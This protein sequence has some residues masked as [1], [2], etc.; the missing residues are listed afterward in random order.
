MVVIIMLGDS[1]VINFKIDKKHKEL[2]FNFQTLKNLYK[3]T[4]QNPFNYLQDFMNSENK[5]D[6]L[7][8]I[9][10]CM[11][12]GDITLEDINDVINN[13][14]VKNY[15]LLN[16]INMIYVELTSEF[17]D[18]EENNNDKDNKND[19]DKQEEKIEE[20]KLQEFENFWNYCYFT[21]T[22]K[23]NKDEEEFYLMSPRE[24]KTLDKYNSNFY[25]NI[26]IDT[27]ITII[28]AKNGNGENKKEEV[29]NVARLSD[30]FH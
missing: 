11:A 10:Y 22:V 28:N 15:L 12:N 23:L 19:N 17:K 30:M 24:L 2:Y 6:F 4:K 26:L 3:L 29:V 5:D 7:G 21:A 1:Y 13:K 18:E 16:I 27:Y 9:I 14:K 25:R 8:S 20:E